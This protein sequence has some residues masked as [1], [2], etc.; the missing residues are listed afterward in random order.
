MGAVSPQ[1]ASPCVHSPSFEESPAVPQFYKQNHASSHSSPIAAPDLQEEATPALEEEAT[2]ALEEE[3]TPALQEEATPALEATTPDAH[4]SGASDVESADVCLQDSYLSTY[5]FTFHDADQMI[6]DMTEEYMCHGDLPFNEVQAYNTWLENEFR[7]SVVGMMAERVPRKLVVTVDDEVCCTVLNIDYLGDYLLPYLRED[8]TSS[9]CLNCHIEI[10]CIAFT[11]SFESGLTYLGICWADNF[12]R[13]MFAR[14][15]FN[16]RGLLNLLERMKVGAMEVITVQGAV[17]IIYYIMSNASSVL[18]ITDKVGV[19]LRTIRERQ[20]MR[21]TIGQLMQLYHDYLA[22]QQMHRDLERRARTEEKSDK[23]L[24]L[25]A[26]R[27]AL[28]KGSIRKRH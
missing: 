4:A 25:K 6:A 2:P 21:P 10:H 14:H 12:K 1:V 11:P 26:V 7:P 13:R 16:Q 20:H 8:E 17:L 9:P 19:D 27:I 18:E 22:Q 23:E 3:A 24:G 15:D 5:S 28:Q